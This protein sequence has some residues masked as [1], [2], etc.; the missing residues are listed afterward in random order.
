VV[1]LGLPHD[2]WR[3]TISQGQ[4]TEML[5]CQDLLLLY[6]SSRLALSSVLLLQETPLSLLVEPFK[7]SEALELRLVPT[8]SLP[9][10][11][12]PTLDLCLPACL[13]PNRALALLQA[14]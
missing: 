10:L 11:P 12:A 14:Y 3:L 5:P 8:Q 13:E 6:S 7:V 1:Q 2:L 9:L 4:N